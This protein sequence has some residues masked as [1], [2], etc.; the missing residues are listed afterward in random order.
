MT[1]LDNFSSVVNQCIQNFS[2]IELS[3]K[4]KNSSFT[5]ENYHSLLLMIFHQVKNS[6][7]SFALAAAQLPDDCESA[8]EYLFHHAEEEKLHWNWVLQDLKNTKYLGPDPKTMYPMPSCQAYIAYNYYIALKFPLGR[9]AIA[10]VLEGYG[11]AYG[12]E[13]ATS[14]SKTLQLK[15]DQMIF[16]LGH[17]D[18]DIGHTKEILDV[19]T[20]TPL[21]NQDLKMMENVAITTSVLYSNM[22]EEVMKA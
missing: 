14:V 1:N 7:S 6:S 15:P 10:S 17:G 8:K 3:K 19:L 13:Y 16:F 2:E 22:Y 21:T 5:L 20:K 4:I 11:A 12:K 9:L 18:T